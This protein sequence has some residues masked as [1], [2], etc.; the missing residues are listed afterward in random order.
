VVL[1]RAHIIGIPGSGKST[2]A[3]WIGQEF[4]IV[5]RDLDFVAYGTDGHERTPEE[6]AAQIEEIRSAARWVTEGA[7]HGDWLKPL[8][9]EAHAIAWLDAPLSA[10][11]TRIV[12][13][14]VRAELARNN[15]HPGW[16]RLVW[17]LNYTRRTA[18]QQRLETATLLSAYPDK[19]TRCR[20]S[21]DVATFKQTMTARAR[22]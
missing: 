22:T 14:H 9:D 18:R 8:L 15:A 3:R 21:R 17:F 10:C 2:L 4:G 11:L 5:A 19:V 20:S 7:Y 1:S 12:K 6:I 13:R 16:R